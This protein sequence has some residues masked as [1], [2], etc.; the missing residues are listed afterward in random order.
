MREVY[1][2]RAERGNGAAG[3][4][5]RPWSVGA[6]R[7]R[8]VSRRILSGRLRQPEVEQLDRDV[9]VAGVSWSPMEAR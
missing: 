2:R 8:A 1:H 3:T 9:P 5:R 4:D 7:G 6:A